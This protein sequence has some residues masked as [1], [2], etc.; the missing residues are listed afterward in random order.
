V[1][2]YQG[3]VWKDVLFADA[4]VAGYV[5]LAHG[6]AQWERPGPRWALVGTGFLCLALATLTR[7]NGIIVLPIGG[8]ATALVAREQGFRWRDAVAAGTGATAAALILVI[9][10]SAALATRT[11][12]A[13]QPEGQLRLLE[14]YDL[15]GEVKSDPALKLEEL[16]RADPRLTSLIR[17]D[18]VRLY[19]PVRNDTLF[20][21]ARLQDALT[22]VDNAAL[23]SQWRQIVFAHPEDYLQTRGHVF[24]WVFATPHIGQCM[25]Y[26][27]GVTGPPQD[28]RQLRLQPRF[29]PQDRALADYAALVA[30]TPLFSHGFYGALVLALFV[31][32]VWR[33][34]SSDIPIACLLAA[35]VAYA[36]SFFVISIACDYR[37]ILVLDLSA[38]VALFYCAASHSG[39]AK[40]GP[41]FTAQ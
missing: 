40:S 39:P 14:L 33:R 7:Q 31:F 20:T 13:P 15:I 35:A 41:R 12:G 25:P 1:L 38:V 37:Y 3:I 24:F 27:T 8:I 11:V 26:Y 28:L 10:A 4:A 17:S 30:R 32:L 9:A 2:L 36:L 18:G 29:R 5:L 19:T 34:R 6:A 16:S 23:A 21:S 22:N